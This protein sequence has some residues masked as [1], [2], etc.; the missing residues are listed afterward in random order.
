MN[1]KRRSEIAVAI[2]NIQSA[3]S[4][5]ESILLDEQT[6]LDNMPENL[7]GSERYENI[8]NAV[9]RLDEA[10]DAL[11]EAIESLEEAMR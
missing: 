7:E 9:D 2:A 3:K 11:Q 5:V 4:D 6:C 1:Q 8:E 10:V